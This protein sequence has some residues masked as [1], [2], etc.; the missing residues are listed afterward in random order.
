MPHH[1]LCV[2]DKIFFN[3]GI[4]PSQPLLAFKRNGNDRRKIFPFFKGGL[5]DFFTVCHLDF[6][7]SLRT[8]RGRLKKGIFC[9]TILFDNMSSS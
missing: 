4:L 7:V 3:Y 9:Y 1:I 5:R 6:D 2:L 8:Q